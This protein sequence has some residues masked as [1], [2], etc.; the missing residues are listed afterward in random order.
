LLQDEEE[1]EK[2]LMMEKTLQEEDLLMLD[3]R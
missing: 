1:S 3:E 2:G